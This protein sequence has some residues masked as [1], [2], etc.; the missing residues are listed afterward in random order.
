MSGAVGWATM[1]LC[2]L[3][4][5]EVYGTASVRNHQ[6]I[7]DAG[8]KPFVYTDKKWMDAIKQLGGAHAVFDSLGFESFD[9]SWECVTSDG[10]LVGYGGMLNAFSGKPEGRSVWGPALK[11]MAR[12]W[13]PFSGRSTNF[14][15]I[16][17]DQATFE[18]NLVALF[19]LLEQGKIE[20]P[21]KGVFDLEDIQEAHRGYTSMGG[22]G[23]F[24]I[25]VSDE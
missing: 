6:A 13:I 7:I 15:Y 20:V 11:L 8:G 23:S 18:P 19:G 5:A 1:K 2:Q 25:K 12:G 16:S 3:Q 14:Y 21:I 10:I 22:V 17:R 4:G 9:E 24:V